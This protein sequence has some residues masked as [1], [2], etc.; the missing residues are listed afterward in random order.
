MRT[1][2][3]LSRAVSATGLDRLSSLDS[4]RTSLVRAVSAL[5]AIGVPIAACVSFPRYWQSGQY[6]LI[7]LDTAVWLLALFS[8]AG[9]GGG[10]RPAGLVLL[11]IF[12][13]MTASFFA[14]LGPHGPRPGWLVTFSVLAALLFGVR[15]AVGATLV[16]TLLLLVAP[17]LL[18]PASAAW[19]STVEAPFGEWLNYVVNTNILAL[20]CGLTVGLLLNALERTLE[21]ERRA[22]AQLVSERAELERAYEKLLEETSE[23]RRLERDLRRAQKIEAVG[24]L[25]GGIAHDLNN[26]LV[27]IVGHAELL[28]FDLPQGSPLQERV[29]D[30]LAAG[31]RARQLVEQIL[32]FSRDVP[33]ADE[34]VAIG[35][36]LQEVVAT[37]EPPSPQK[38]R[39]EVDL[40]SWDT[41]R[42][43]RTALFQVFMNLSSNGLAAMEEEGGTL[44]IRTTTLD[45]SEAIEDRQAQLQ[46][47]RAYLCVS[48][49]DTGTGMEPEVASRVFE[50]FFTT[51]PFGKG[52]GLGLATSHGIVAA[53][54]GC[55]TLETE[56]GV[57]TTFRVYLPIAA[58]PPTERHTSDETA[59]ERVGETRILLVD[60]NPH[61]LATVRRQ[62]EHL[63]YRVTTAQSGPAALS[64]LEGE[65]F[66]LVLSDLQ[67]PD[68]DGLE[69]CE[70][71]SRRFPDM[72]LVL[73]SG[74]ADSSTYGRVEQVGIRQVIAKPFST[75]EIAGVLAKALRG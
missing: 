25:A 19:Q 36:L 37:L 9:R 14:Q 35:P 16:S 49:S 58:A 75:A 64:A 50:P 27:P 73:A 69:L 28:G 15:G 55:L 59:L 12:A 47:D 1:P 23:R 39:V 48:V 72:P 3:L 20:G 18:H 7:A 52:T 6:G 56:P 66:D 11:G 57:G 65:A 8:A 21:K 45:P 29:A 40:D 63:G 46:P 10:L 70:T 44:R 4:W 33:P 30:I 13:A 22:R 60:D 5:F 51:K 67:M 17:S 41:V 68:M 26:V 61:T 32:L 71:I 53:F 43:N 42:A 54:E 34:Y 62:L 24:R 2:G 31:Q 74:Y 38:I